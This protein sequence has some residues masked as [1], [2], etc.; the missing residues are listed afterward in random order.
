MAGD[1]L[2]IQKSE[3]FLK[4]EYTQSET[5]TVEDSIEVQTEIETETKTKVQPTEEDTEETP[6][7]TIEQNS[8]PQTSDE[9]IPN[10]LA[11]VQ[12][13][14]AQMVISQRVNYSRLSHS[15]AYPSTDNTIVV[16]SNY[17]IS[18]SAPRGMPTFIY[19]NNQQGYYV[20]LSRERNVR[21]RHF[22]I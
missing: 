19:S 2:L 16:K 15:Y 6:T 5:A 18:I 7:Q 14:I 21:P 1:T 22:E 12:D 9:Q 11:I 13:P 8:A 20:K 17:G 10:E 3:P 4:V